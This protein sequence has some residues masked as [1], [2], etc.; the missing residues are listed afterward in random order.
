M[1]CA[2]R[3]RHTYHPWPDVAPGTRQ[4]MK[5]NKAKDT[6]PEMAV[7]RFLHG[8]GYRYRLHCK[9]LPGKPDLVFRKRRKIVEVRGCYWHGHSCKIGRPARSIT[10]YWVPK[11]ARNKERDAANLEALRDAGWDV[12]EVWECS[13]RSRFVEVE[14]DLKNF[15]GS[16]RAGTGLSGRA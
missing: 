11:I 13:L 5:G 1:K 12:L 7:R 6:S 8:L 10:T 2:S 16:L 14:S 3:Q 9:D 4:A 15:L